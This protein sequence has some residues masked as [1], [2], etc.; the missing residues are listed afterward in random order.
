M[1]ARRCGAP[2]S[3]PSRIK[4]I[5]FSFFSGT[6]GL[7]IYMYMAG[8][9]MSYLDLDTP[10]GA[11]V[12]CLVDWPLRKHAIS[13]SSPLDSIAAFF[14]PGGPEAW[15]RARE[16]Q[17]DTSVLTAKLCK[18]SSIPISQMKRPLALAMAQEQTEGFDL[19]SIWARFFLLLTFAIWA[20]VTVHDLALI[21]KRKKHFILD[22]T[23]INAHCPS[24]RTFWRAL[25]GYRILKR[26]VAEEKYGLKALGVGIAII[27]APVLV[28]WNLILFNFFIVPL[29]LLAFARYPIR[30]SR[31]WVFI[32]CCAC[33]IYGFGLAMQQLSFVTNPDIRPRYAVTWPSDVEMI[34]LDTN[35]TVSGGCTCGCDFPIS[36]TVCVNLMII[37]VLT[38]IKSI[39]LAFRCLKGLR[40]SQWANL[41]SVM[42]PVPITMYAVDWKQSNG[43]PIRF[44]TEDVPVQGELAFD[45]FAM[46]DE[47]I[48][49]A[50]TTINLR[51][52]PVHRYEYDPESKEFNLVAPS[53]HLEMPSQPMPAFR[54]Q[55]LQV[56]KMEYIG[57]C[58]FPWP[59]GGS[60]CVYDPGFVE[61][62]QEL[63][64]QIA[65]SPAEKSKEG[66]PNEPMQNVR[67]GILPEA[68]NGE[69]VA[70][71][72]ID[73][74]GA[75]H[76]VV[77]PPNPSSG[78]GEEDPGSLLIP[79]HERA[80]F[81]RFRL[82]A[83]E[84]GQGSPDSPQGRLG[85][86]S[87]RL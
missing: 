74:Y 55:D 85:L 63:D 2:P 40:R 3:W 17:C 65:A 10:E 75:A 27:L 29:L 38:T 5:F 23:G 60:Q 31:A 72:T 53:R 81:S 16:Q 67:K 64:G 39:F 50:S 34:R 28:V 37:G 14:D 56:K 12:L 11:N 35:T 68:Q 46:M 49:S 18:E 15:T 58:G 78:P 57:C 7:S 41:L 52:D 19:L 66:S 21:G 69:G 59:T 6:L 70:V 61:K 71:V 4:V 76:G 83:E 13:W 87:L 62:L 33:C 9:N 80:P 82:Q 32:S 51:P 24:I 26:L 45:P 84:V 42:F 30:M 44:R 77:P 54:P 48:D 43:Q 73:K 1:W 22:V 8:S 25:A 79:P 86:D 47:Q 20:G 36:F